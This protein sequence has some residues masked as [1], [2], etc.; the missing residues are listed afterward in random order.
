[1][2]ALFHANPLSLP[3]AHTSRRTGAMTLSPANRHGCHRK[4]T[5]LMKA[6]VEDPAQKTFPRNRRL[7]RQRIL[8]LSGLHS[9]PQPG[10]G[11]TVSAPH[12]GRPEE[13][14]QMKK[15]GPIFI[16]L[17]VLV[18]L[19]FASQGL[20][21]SVPCVCVV[22]GRRLR[23]RGNWPRGRWPSRCQSGALR[24]HH[25]HPLGD[26]LPTAKVATG[27]LGCSLWNKT[28]ASLE[29]LV[30]NLAENQ[31]EQLWL[32]VWSDT[33]SVPWQH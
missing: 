28:E 9:L 8:P 2:P 7:A 33:L 26:T 21:H 29:H 5:S 11:T 23:G 31:E 16:S 1:M 14:T 4:W 10:K 20:D 15:L 32:Q 12:W 19:P 25:P 24:S 22:K 30:K 6:T 13:G 27:L 3:Y 18:L 17:L